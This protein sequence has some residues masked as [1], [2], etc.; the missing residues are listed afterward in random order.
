MRN[1][2]SY[3]CRARGRRSLKS[4]GEIVPRRLGPSR[5]AVPLVC[6][7]DREPDCTG[8]VGGGRLRPGVRKLGTG[9]A[10]GTGKALLA[11]A[12]GL[13]GRARPAADH[14]LPGSGCRQQPGLPARPRVLGP[15]GDGLARID[16]RRP[17]A[18]GAEP[19]RAAPPRVSHA[20]GDWTESAALS[21]R[22]CAS[23]R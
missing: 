1:S 19:A 2:T 11:A 18:G 14:L 4:A 8:V 15:A 12:L 23:G 10:R 3:S 7:V 9:A 6:G 16:A 20:G 13:P 21:R 5:R 22:A 17:A